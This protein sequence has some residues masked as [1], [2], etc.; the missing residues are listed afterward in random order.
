MG[1]NAIAKN[2]RNI[3]GQTL[4]SIEAYS[5]VIKRPVGAVIIFVLPNSPVPTSHPRSV[6]EFLDIYKHKLSVFYITEEEA[7]NLSFDKLKEMVE[8]I[9]YP[10][11]HTIDF[12]N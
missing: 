5:T 1:R 7:E 9:Q 10:Q 8:S 11:Q 12:D 2:I 6:Q 4:S 3:V